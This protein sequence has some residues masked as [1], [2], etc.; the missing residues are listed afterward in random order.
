MVPK[1]LKLWYSENTVI[2]SHAIMHT[3]IEE[4]KSRM[5]LRKYPWETSL[6]IVRERNSDITETHTFDE[7][8]WEC[9]E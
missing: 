9:I 1:I 8:R 3:S 6:S 7:N 2:V 5:N 4:M